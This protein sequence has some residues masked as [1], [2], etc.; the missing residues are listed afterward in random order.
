MSRLKPDCSCRPV[1]GH[2]KFAQSALSNNGSD[3]RA[4]IFALGLALGLTAASPLGPP[5]LSTFRNYFWN[6]R[7]ARRGKFF[8]RLCQRNWH[9]YANGRVVE[10]SQN[11]SQRC[12]PLW[13]N[14]AD[15]QELG[16]ET[17][18]KLGARRYMG[19]MLGYAKLGRVNS[20]DCP[21]FQSEH[22]WKCRLV[23]TKLKAFGQLTYVKNVLYDCP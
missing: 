10:R 2:P 23:D 1:T 9:R 15:I 7:R 5:A 8:H 16:G 4:I 14:G 17:S 11:L 22:Y 6:A 21:E 20:L 12:Y 18:R 19:V 13:R 3:Y